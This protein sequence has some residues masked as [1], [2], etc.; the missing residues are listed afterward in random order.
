MLFRSYVNGCVTSWFITTQS[1]VNQITFD[2]S[3]TLTVDSIIFHQSKISFSLI[4]DLLTVNLDE[5]LNLDQLDSISIYYQG[6]PPKST[7]FGDSFVQDF[8]D[9]SNTSIPIIFTLS[10]PYGAKDWWPCKQSLTDKID[11]IDIFVTMPIG[12]KAAGNG[13]LISEV[14]DGD[15][16]IDHWKHRHPIAAYLIGISVTNYV[17]YSDYIPYDNFD[18]LQVLNYVFPENL[19]ESQLTSASIKPIFQKIEQILTPYPFKNEKYGHAQFTWMGGMEHQTMTFLYNFSIDLMSHELAHQWFGDLI[20][21]ASWQDIWVNEGF[22]TFLNGWYYEYEANGYYKYIWRKAVINYVTQLSDGSVYCIDTTSVS[23][24]F[25]K[26]LSY[27]KAA[28]LIQM[29]RWEL[30]EDTFWL[31]IRNYLN[32]PALQNN[33]AT[34]NDVKQHF[35]AAADTNLTEFFNDWCYGEG[36]PQYSLYWEQNA[37]N[38]V[39]L[40]ISQIPSHSSVNFYEMHVPIKFVGNEKD[41]IVTFKH[42]YSGQ[43]FSVPLNFT[44]DSIIFDPEYWLIAKSTISQGINDINKQSKFKISPNPVNDKL[45]IAFQKTLKIS[46]IEIINSDGSCVQ[47][48]KIN[49]TK[50]CLDLNLTHL[51]PG[52]YLVKIYTNEDIISGKFIKQ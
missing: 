44:V 13:V 22:A 26:R 35:E 20:T 17:A 19:A 36:Y 42:D 29:L 48:I 30:G 12:N 51:T 2:L 3:D 25:S 23:R 50:E 1:N 33:Y 43:Q 14:I 9:T 7:G 37:N 8:H 10:E 21:C 16:K 32:D 49:Q 45:H 6:V 46:K 11:S 18:S 28:L 24:I 15:K 52:V 41:T 38:V 4:E 27:N 5:T 34:T 39:S 31:A 47:T 40:E